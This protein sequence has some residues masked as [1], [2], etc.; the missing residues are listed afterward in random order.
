MSSLAFS[1]ALASAP[2]AMSDLDSR[3]PECS[4][5][6]MGAFIER[7]RDDESPCPS[8]RRVR[9]EHCHT[10]CFCSWNL[11]SSSLAW[12][13]HLS[14]AVELGGSM[15]LKAPN[16]V[17]DLAMVWSSSRGHAGAGPWALHVT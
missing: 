7:Q 4:G 12:P 15:T 8:R 6:L 3:G 10:N 14:I 11:P 17:R 16:E 5:T 1:D 13:S 2:P 9:E